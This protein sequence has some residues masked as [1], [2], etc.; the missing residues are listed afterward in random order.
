MKLVAIY[1]K[2]ENPAAFDQAY[3]NTHIPLIKQ[4]PGIRQT[5]IT[6][7]TRGVVGGEDLYLMAEMFFE[8]KDALKTAMRSEEMGRAGENLDSFAKGLY[9]LVYAEEE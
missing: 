1:N 9:T 3:F 7:F 6:R 4:V 2:P 8:D 5:R